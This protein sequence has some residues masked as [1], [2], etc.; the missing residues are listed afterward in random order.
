M[1]GP[2][3]NNNT[4][5]TQA[6]AVGPAVRAMVLLGRAAAGVGHMQDIRA[7]IGLKVGSRTGVEEGVPQEVAASQQKHALHSLDAH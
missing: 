1:R 2:A 5:G 6:E 7:V 4:G 3:N